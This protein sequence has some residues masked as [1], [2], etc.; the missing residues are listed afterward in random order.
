MYT[1]VHSEGFAE[2]IVEIGN[3]FGVTPTIVNTPDGGYTI[4][5]SGPQVHFRLVESNDKF[6]L[7]HVSRNA[8][9]DQVIS[10]CLHM[11]SERKSWY[12]GPQQKRQ[13]WPIEKSVYSS[14]SYVTKEADNCG[15]AERYWL[16]SDGVFFYVDDKAPLFIDQNVNGNHLC[17]VGKKQLPYDTYGDS[18]TFGYYIGIGRDARQVHMEAVNRFLGKPRG[19]PDERMVKHPVWSTWARYKRDINEVVVQEFADEVTRYGFKNS[20]IEIDDDWEV[21]Y[22]A[23]TFRES[24]FPDVKALTT[25]LKANGFKVTLWVHPFINEGCEPWYGEAKEK[26]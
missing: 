17:F 3:G 24:K 10:D 22:G 13:Y 16:N 23:L 12:G 6:A 4:R 26:G 5:G 20:Q 19:H 25:K 8:I 14:Y 15:I 7:V 21:C 2:Q 9:R 18:F 11:N 1:Y